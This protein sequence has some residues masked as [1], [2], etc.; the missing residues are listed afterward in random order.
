VFDLGNLGWIAP[1]AVALVL[2]IVTAGYVRS[3]W[4]KAP[5]AFN[6]MKLVGGLFFLSGFLFGIWTLHLIAPRSEAPI[7]EPV[8]S[9]PG[10]S[11]PPSGLPSTPSTSSIANGTSFGT[12]DTGS[13]SAAELGKAIA[14]TDAEHE[15]DPSWTPV[16]ILG[17]ACD[18]AMIQADSLP[19][20]GAYLALHSSGRDLNRGPQAKT[21]PLAD[22]AAFCDKGVIDSKSTLCIRAHAAPTSRRRQ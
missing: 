19:C 5:V 11:L 6:A 16:E 17:Q 4:R 8:N 14:A 1:L 20:R 15:G 3:R 21:I 2:A 7:I 9:L 12:L 18:Q 10:T 13:V 22:I